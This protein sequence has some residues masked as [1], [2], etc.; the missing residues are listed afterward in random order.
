[1]EKL[2]IINL[3]KA[4]TPYCETSLSYTEMLGLATNVLLQ[5][6]TFEEASIPS[7]SFLMKQPKNDVGDVLYYDLDYAS[8]VMHAFIYEDIKPENYIQQNPIQKNDWYA[9]IRKAK[10]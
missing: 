3:I 4:L 5:K 1:M 8:K 9:E 7:R 6:P 10:Q 2:Q